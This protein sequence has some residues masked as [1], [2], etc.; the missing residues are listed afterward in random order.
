MGPGAGDAAFAVQ[1]GQRLQLDRRLGVAGVHGDGEAVRAAA[2]DADAAGAQQ[3]LEALGGDPV[4][5]ATGRSSADGGRG[6]DHEQVQD[7]DVLQADGGPE[8]LDEQPTAH[9][10]P[11][12]SRLARRR[13]REVIWR[14]R[15]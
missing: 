5:V 1:V 7:D 14:G 11:S 9:A 4:D 6:H 10:A 8:G 15:P 13:G 3:P 12:P 2:Q